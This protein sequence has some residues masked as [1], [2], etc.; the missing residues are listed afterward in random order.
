MDKSLKIALGSLGVSLVV[1]AVKFTA[2]LITGSLA[3]YSDALE[4]IIN[5]ATSIAAI[6][7]IRIAARPPD[8]EHPY[9]YHKAEYMSAVIIGALI[10][11][12][13]LT[14]L[15]EAYGGFLAPR[16]IDALW[17]GLTIGMVATILNAGWGVRLTRSSAKV[18]RPCCGWQA[19]AGRCGH[20]SWCPRRRLLTVLTGI[21]V[22][23]AWYCRARGP[24]CALERL[25]DP[26]RKCARTDG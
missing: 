10:I 26:A 21:A 18:C 17:T 3:L 6:I 4:S 14:I 9:G 8:A 12:A 16:A 22:L 19:H 23:D 7:A 25:S 15:H 2:Y 20:L 13:A 24:A 11:A 1:L 5:V